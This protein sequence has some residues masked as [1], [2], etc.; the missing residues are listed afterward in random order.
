MF[1]GLFSAGQERQLQTKVKA[2]SGMSTVLPYGPPAVG[3][4]RSDCLNP[5]QG[6]GRIPGTRAVNQ[7][8]AG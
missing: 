5:R 8:F 6:Q 3:T 4:Q 1:T 7:G 2:V